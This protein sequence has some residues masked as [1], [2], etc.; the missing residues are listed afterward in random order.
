MAVVQTV[1]MINN[2]AFSNV[3]YFTVTLCHFD[4]VTEHTFCFFIFY[5]QDIFAVFIYSGD[6]IIPFHRQGND[7]LDFWIVHPVSPHTLATAPL[8]H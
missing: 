2:E 1:Y 5:F 6:V 3:F 8:L 7:C 4:I